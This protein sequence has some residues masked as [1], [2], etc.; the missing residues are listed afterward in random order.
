MSSTSLVIDETLWDFDL[1]NR[2]AA[3]FYGLFLR[4]HTLDELR[5]DIDVP[6]DVLAKWQRDAERDPSLQDAVRRMVEYRHRVLA[7]FD[8]LIRIDSSPTCVQ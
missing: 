8:S 4:G 7:I 2:E 6:A 5:R 3:F 1:P